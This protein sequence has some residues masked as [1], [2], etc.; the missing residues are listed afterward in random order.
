MKAAVD[1]ERKR[2]QEIDEIAASIGDKK[3][4]EEAKF[5][6]TPM[7]AKTLAF[8]A[9][10]KQKTLGNQFLEDQAEDSQNSGVNNVTPEPNAGTKTKEE[11]KAQDIRDGAAM[12]AGIQK[13]DKA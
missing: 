5:G 6:E 11:Q 9:L 7:D 3:L 2:I 13:G 8:E 1:A 4:I 12:I 10:K